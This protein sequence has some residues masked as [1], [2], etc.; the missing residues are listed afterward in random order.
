MRTICD[1]DN[2]CSWLRLTLI[3][4]ALQRAFFQVCGISI[5][6]MSAYCGV[7]TGELEELASRRGPG[8]GMKM[9]CGVQSDGFFNYPP[10]YFGFLRRQL[11]SE[12]IGNGENFWV[13]ILRWHGEGYKSSCVSNSKVFLEILIN[14]FSVFLSQRLL[15]LGCFFLSQEKRSNLWESILFAFAANEKLLSQ[16]LIIPPNNF[17]ICVCY[18]IFRRYLMSWGLRNQKDFE[19]KSRL[20]SYVNCWNTNMF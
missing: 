14:I 8:R 10:P 7:S 12:G 16:W 13:K 20:I 11:K 19:I 17:L 9:R 6:I 18:K 1:I 5:W 15:S 2:W 3:R 4:C